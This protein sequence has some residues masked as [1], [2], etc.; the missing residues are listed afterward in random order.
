MEDGA[1]N[2]GSS[3]WADWFQGVAGSVIGKAADAQYVKPYDVQSLRLQA[4][5][6]GGY[7]TEGMPGTRLTGTG[8]SSGTLLLIGAALVAVL[9]L[10][11]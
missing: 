5:G 2:T 7:Y 4:L 1:L 10:K 3:N 6:N 9:V 8:L 11:D